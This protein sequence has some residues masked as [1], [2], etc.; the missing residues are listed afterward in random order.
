MFL[1]GIKCTTAKANNHLIRNVQPGEAHCS[2]LTVK[3]HIHEK[4]DL[5]EFQSSVVRYFTSNYLVKIVNQVH[6]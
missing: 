3:F 2:V 4:R 6:L 1:E 5:Y